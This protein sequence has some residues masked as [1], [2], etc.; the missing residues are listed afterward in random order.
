VQA[1][2]IQAREECA[3]AKAFD[4]ILANSHYSRESIL[5]AYGL[6][7]KVCYLGVDT[8]TFSRS[9]NTRT[10]ELVGVGAFVGEKNIGFVIEAVGA[11]R[12]PRPRL[13]WVGN[14][15]WPSYLDD[16][17]RLAAKLNVDFNHRVRIADEE[18]LD[19][20]SRSMAFVYAPRLEPFGLAPLEAGACGLPV[21]AVAEGGVRETIFDEVNGLVVEHDPL[22][23]AAAIERLRD[24]PEHAKALGET[25]QRLVR[26]RWTMALAIDRLETRLDEVLSRKREATPFPMFQA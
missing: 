9:R 10:T 14:V 24:N 25:G 3:N 15:E 12:P 4:V 23:M 17:K 6:D 5:R 8:K 22:A 18:L 1:L 16:L 13:T 7:S 11:V 19:I 21:I 26:E 2:R 20:L